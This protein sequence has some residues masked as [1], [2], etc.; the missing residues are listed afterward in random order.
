M[1]EPTEHRKEPVEDEA[2]DQLK[3]ELRHAFSAPEHSYRMLTAAEVIGRNAGSK[4]KAYPVP[5]ESEQEL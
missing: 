1:S 5:I 2:L 4:A 3:S